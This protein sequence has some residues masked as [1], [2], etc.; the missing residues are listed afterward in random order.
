MAG[1]GLN[2]PDVSAIFMSIFLQESMPWYWENGMPPNENTRERMY[3]EH[4]EPLLS[5]DDVGTPDCSSDDD[6]AN[7]AAATMSSRLG[8]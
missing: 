2:L 8:Y 6:D 5:D 3:R 1:E 7:Y 4:R